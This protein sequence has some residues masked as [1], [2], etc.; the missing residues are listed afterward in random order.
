[1]SNKKYTKTNQREELIKERVTKLRNVAKKRIAEEIEER[2]KRI[3]S[4]QEVNKIYT[5]RLKDFEK[6]LNKTNKGLATGGPAIGGKKID[7][8]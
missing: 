4:K 8:L 6:R 1:M 3:P 2:E 7:R 5:N